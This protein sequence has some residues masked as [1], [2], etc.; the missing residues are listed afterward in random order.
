VRLDP[1]DRL[2]I[3]ERTR[4]AV[5]DGWKAAHEAELAKRS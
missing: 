4:N 1:A 2:K 5:M 3:A